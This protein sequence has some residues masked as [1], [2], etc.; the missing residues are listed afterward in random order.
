MHIVNLSLNVFSSQFFQGDPT[1]EVNSWIPRRP[2]R[3]KTHCGYI[4]SSLQGPPF[5]R[6]RS[7]ESAE[8]TPGILCVDHLK[9]IARTFWNTLRETTETCCGNP[10]NSLL[11][12]RQHISGIP[13]NTLLVP[14][15]VINGIKRGKLR[16]FARWGKKFKFFELSWRAM[17]GFLIPD[18][19][20]SGRGSKLVFSAC[21]R[22]PLSLTSNSIWKQL[23]HRLRDWYIGS[24]YATAYVHP[25]R[26]Q[27]RY[28]KRHSFTLIFILTSADLYCQGHWC[29]SFRDSPTLFSCFF[30]E[31]MSR[32]LYGG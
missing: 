4:E 7:L 13:W 6:C 21:H 18:W 11:R 17:L 10:G 26:C 2:L 19:R 15:W 31:P 30:C 9:H 8:G 16:K 5:T 27:H 3:S 1:G 23:R 22:S 25:Y 32:H 20:E 14:R 29:A 12:P 24:D 28:W